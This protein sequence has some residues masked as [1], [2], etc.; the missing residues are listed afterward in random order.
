VAT[1]LWALERLGPDH[2]YV[3][4][5]G[6][7][8]DLDAKSGRL[9]GQLVVD[10]TGD[11][12]FHTDNALILARSLNEHG[13]RSVSDGLVVAGP[14]TI[15]WEKGAE[16]RIPD[17]VQRA[18]AMARKL[19]DTL[20]PK[21]WGRT[22]RSAWYALARRR[23]WDPTDPP[24]LRIQGPTT[25]ASQC[26][27]VPLARHLSN[28]LRVEL[29]RFNVYSNN[30][31]IRVA[32]NLGGVDELEHYLEARLEVAPEEV[33][34]ETASGEG[35]NQLSARTVVRLLRAFRAT[36]TSLELK[37][38]DLL[39]VPG[40]DPGPL[41]HMLPRLATGEPARRLAVKTGTL[42]ITD[43]GVAVLSGYLDTVEHGN[44]LFCVAATRA[45][46]RINHWRAV[47]SAWVTNL[48]SKLGG[49]EMR[50]CAPYLPLADSLVEVESVQ[51][52][53]PAT[54]ALTS[55]AVTL[56]AAR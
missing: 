34:L 28:P 51:Q 5:A 7:R 33:E 50:Q 29:R 27:Y 22:T 9:E 36:L 4:T 45:G 15:G 55:A 37:P 24:G 46:R 40:C 47:E 53:S 20:D 12:D 30:D 56:L 1:S 35:H 3:T 6:I 21:R 44:V 32:D 19:R 17:P 25:F 52:A 14:F 18:E 31:I 54:A 43:D 23:G 2:R 41:Q 16:A 49:A 39:P 42:R 10:S 26:E 8:G 48:M 13:L 38:E 11:P